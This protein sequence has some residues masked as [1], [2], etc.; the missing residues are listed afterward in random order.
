MD[1]L[2][3]LETQHPSRE[4]SKV[5][6][7]LL[8]Q[9]LCGKIHKPESDAPILPRP[10]GS[11]VPL[12]AEQHRLWLHAQTNPGV[13]IYNESVTIHRRGS[14]DLAVFEAAFNEFLR[15]HEAWRTSFSL[16]EGEPVQI[17]HPHLRIRVP[18]VDLSSMPEESREAEARRLAMRDA[19][20]PI[21]LEPA[22]LFRIIA[23]R[24]TSEDHRVY[25]TLHHIIFDGVSIYQI[26]VP[27]LAALYD[28]FSSG[29]PSPLPEPRLQYGDYSVWRRN[30]LAG[31]EVARQLEY[32]KRQL[33]GDLPVLRLPADRNRPP[34]PTNRG[35]M[36]CFSLPG[37]LLHRLQALGHANNVTLFITLLAAYKALLF[38]YSGQ[39]DV[40]IGTVHDARRRIELRGMPGYLLDTLPIRT[41][42]TVQ[43]RFTQ[44]LAEV[45]DTLLDALA[46]ADVPF[47]RIVQAVQPQRSAQY[48]P[49]FQAFFALEPP[50][51]GFPSGWDLTQ[52]DVLPGAAKFDLY[53]ELEER[54]DGMAGRVLYSTDLFDAGTI[55]RMIG[56]FNSILEALCNDPECTLATLPLLTPF[57]LA[58][59]CGPD[60][61]NKTARSFPNLTLHQLI[62]AQAS[63][64]PHAIA[65]ESAGE[66]WTYSQLIA[67]ANTIA[68][69][70]R[71]AGA[72]RGSV[73]A[74]VLHRSLDLLAGLLAIL[75]AG[76]AYLPLDPEVPPARRNSCLHAA[77]PAVILTE[78]SIKDVPPNV[79]PILIVE[80]LHELNVE[81]KVS[82]SP[83]PIA[84]PSDLAYVIYTSGTTGNPKGVEIPHSAI[85]N[86]LTSMQSEPGF[87]C[88]DRLLAVTTV[89]FDIAALELFLPLISGGCVI[90]AASDVARDPI[91]LASAIETSKCTVMQ[92]TPATWLAL[93]SAG[94]KRP[95]PQREFKILCGGEPLSR[96]L[97]NRLL[98]A[99][100]E[101]WNMYG[102]TETTVWSTLHRVSAAS[103]PVSIG[104]PIANTCAYILDD[105]QQLVPIGVPGKLYLGGAGLARGYRNQNLLTSE[106]FAFIPAL[107]NARLY[108]TGDLAVRLADGNIECLGRV[109]NQVKIRGF[110]VELE[111][112]E[113][114]VRRHPNVSAA[115]ARVWPDAAGSTRL[116]VYVVGREGPPPDQAGLRQYLK[117]DQP[118][119][120]IPS[121]VIA[122]DALPLS[123]NGKID[124]AR[125]P[126]PGAA[127][128]ADRLVKHKTEAEEKLALIWSDLLQVNAVDSQDDFFDLGGHSLLVATLQSRI[129]AG[130]GRRIPMA[131]LFH[132][133]TL[134]QQALLLEPE[135]LAAPAG[136]IPLQTKGERPPL[137]WLCPPPDI[138]RLAGALGAD[139][140]VMGVELTQTDI[141]V[142]SDAPS[143]ER[144]ATRF[145]QSILRAQ[146]RGP[147]Y[148]GGLCVGGIV[149]FETAA[150]MIALGHD[151][152]L[153]VLLDAQNP[154]F[155]KRIGSLQVELS[156]AYFYLKH[157]L[158]DIH[159]QRHATLHQRLARFLVRTGRSRMQAV[160]KVEIGLGGRITEAAAYRYRPPNYSGDVLLLQP[161]DRPSRV[162]HRPG[163]EAAVSGKL[164]ARDVEGHHDVLL[165]QTF[166]QS[167]ARVVSEHLS[168]NPQSFLA[169]EKQS[170]A[171]RSRD[172][173]AD[174]EPLMVSYAPAAGAPVTDR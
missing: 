139:Q 159:S 75:K 174:A 119:Y 162:D 166:V 40:I 83:A 80:E 148:L 56:H 85:V 24:M 73:V 123:Q 6:R 108:D 76:A 101:L 141:D 19:A 88:R 23:I 171:S 64:T 109:D 102:P 32:W 7:L 36:E 86:L 104:K 96:E 71:Q 149:A 146:P 68:A 27:E 142:L 100:L 18:F 140:P 103:G 45:R 97:A 169:G 118:E 155:Y 129:H 158:C 112:V 33:A 79:A 26:V 121:D 62:E 47:D 163:W 67:R 42:P 11:V 29:R 52:M 95:Q 157:A 10:A 156:K 81:T 143:M 136:I 89:C 154:V 107:G 135:K 20:I 132:S 70:L 41:H 161:K 127:R 1:T 105:Q 90:I 15:R 160:P 65:A 98:G 122:L 153:L 172:R 138:G 14:F 34:R 74:V 144:I 12:S 51:T 28:A 39:R 111:A 63:R 114:A 72:T 13:P 147:F 133:A 61:W 116:S 59:L 60:G 46:A 126:F 115:A 16:A 167:L 84:D 94:W 110:R 69:H 5:K 43:T 82:D 49:I 131:A 21:P 164:I 120:M 91:L 48:H 4:L 55:Q 30:H 54:I 99:G 128:A 150:Q 78:Q 124:R 37:E 2:V 151:V 25:L 145:M 170:S 152:R 165:S 31:P 117:S 53:L 168:G 77:W 35:A 87:T 57:E 66:R 93:L 58:Q 106:R 137:F 3:A 44:L 125:L 134:E 173:L 17:V 9:R 92:A 22:P 113:E 8:E 130:F 50:G 38:R